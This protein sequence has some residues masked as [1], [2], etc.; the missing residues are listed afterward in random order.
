[1]TERLLP[2]LDADLPLAEV[3]PRAAGYEIEEQLVAAG[4]LR[5]AG[6][7][8]VG[9]GAW[10]GPVIVCAVIT[11]LSAPPELPRPDGN[12]VRL[13][14]SKL[15][16]ARYREAFAKVLPGW[17]VSYAFGAAGPEEIDEFGMTKALRRAAIRALETFPQRPDAVLLDGKHNYIGGSWGNAGYPSPVHQQAL[18]EFGPTRHHRLS[19]SYLDDLPQWKHLKKHRDP[20]AGE[21]QL[22]LL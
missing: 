5:V 4:A 14:D 8:E 2:G 9:R 7:D 6:V 12:P 17:L 19:W 18:A 3:Q 21:G 15:L 10:A 16:T 1:V 11:D 22:T 13:T 20:H